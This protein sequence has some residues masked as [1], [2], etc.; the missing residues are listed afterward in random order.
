MDSPI[1]HVGRFVPHSSA[2]LVVLTVLS[3]LVNS[4]TMGYDG[5]MMNGLNILPSFYNTINLNTAG[6]S[7]NTGIIW[8]GGCVAGF[9]SGF[10]LDRYGRKAGMAWAVYM[11]SIGII[12]QSSAQNPAMFLVGRLIVGIGVGLS[13]VACPTYVSEVSQLK[14]RAFSLGFYYDFWYGGGI[15]ASAITYGTAKIDSSWAWRIPSIIQVVPSLLCL[16]ILPFIPE[17]PRWLMYQ[18]RQDE[19]L[20]VLAIMAANGDT[21]D[22]VVVTQYHQIADTIA[23]EKANKPSINWLDAFRTPQSRRRMILACS[24]AIFGNMS[25]SGIISYYLGTILTQAGVTN[26]TTQLEINIY[27]SVWCLFTAILGTS[28]ADKIGRKRLGA[29]TLTVSMVFLFLVGAF[30]KLYGDGS[31]KSGVYGTVACIFLY[32]GSYAFGWSTLLVMYP[33]E[34]LNYS[35]R[36]NGM[37]IYTFV[38]NA[39]ATVV[40]FAFP[41]ALAKIGWKTYMINAS[42]DVLEIAFI[43]WY[44]VETSGKTLEEVDELI[45]GEYHSDAPVLLGVIRGEVEV[46]VKEGME[47][48]VVETG[49]G[50]NVATQ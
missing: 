49:S 47:V 9:F 34:V 15:I 46:G 45:D 5:N 38:S 20:E 13:S 21:S 6:E 36:A 22:A 29:G 41:Y 23:W 19:A 7:A 25:G 11:T 28:L 24:C 3:C 16:V 42:W 12:L 50:R 37:S 10:I 2:A 18:D 48:K 40:T 1:R 32:Q 43:I 14:W 31:T 4:M 44:W 8:V 33:P 35:L 27:L 26:T 17:S 30:T 39:A